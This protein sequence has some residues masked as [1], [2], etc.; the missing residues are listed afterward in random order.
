M[1]DP[2]IHRTPKGEFETLI[3]ERHMNK[4]LSKEIKLQ[5]EANK[6]L[7]LQNNDLEEEIAEM[8]YK[9][10]KDEMGQIILKNKRLKDEVRMKDVK[11]K[12]Y[13]GDVFK[14]QQDI[15]RLQSRMPI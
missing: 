8:I 15:I 11:L 9:Y 2:L 13:K 1:D 12:A 14:L 10:K 7:H 3:W 4:C 5:R 6:K